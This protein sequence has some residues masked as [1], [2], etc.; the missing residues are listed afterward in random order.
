MGVI[1]ADNINKFKSSEFLFS[2]IKREFKSFSDVN[3]LNISDFPLYTA[4]VLKNLGISVFKEEETITTVKNGK[5]ILPQDFMLLHAA[6]K[7]CVKDITLNDEHLQNTSILY[8]DVTCELIGRKTGCDL[9]CDNERI[10]QKITTR[11]YIK[12]GCLKRDYEV[13][14]LLKLSPNVK[15]LCSELC[16]NLFQTTSDEITINN[17][18][19]YTNF[20]DGDIYMKYYAFPT[21]ENNTP[22]I[23][24]IIQVEKAIEWYIKWQLLLNFWLVDDLQNAQNKWA[25]AEQEYEKAF[26][27]AKYILK[28][29]SFSSLI[30][31]L[32]NTRGINKLAYFSKNSIH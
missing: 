10:L 32:H 1:T 24:D 15:P 3:L 5:A 22:L 17:N 8:N 4:E 18:C 27:E 20:N 26:A 11:Q 7:C 23:P 31:S 28:L 30:N 29:P 9:N 19:I 12:E 14:H 16:L 25:K 13:K 2:K 6:Y 21:D